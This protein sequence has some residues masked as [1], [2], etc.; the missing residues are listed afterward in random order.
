V[1]SVLADQIVPSLTTRV[2]RNS[3]DIVRT[4]SFDSSAK[5]ANPSLSY[6]VH[7]SGAT[8][9]RDIDANSYF[10]P[11]DRIARLYSS[12]AVGLT[13]KEAIKLGKNVHQTDKKSAPKIVGVNLSATAPDAFG[14]ANRINAIAQGKTVTR[15]KTQKH[16]WEAESAD[17]MREHHRMIRSKPGYEMKPVREAQVFEDF[18]EFGKDFG[19]WNP[20]SLNPVLHEDEEEATV[21]RSIARYEHIK[22]IKHIKPTSSMLKYLLNPLLLY[23]YLKYLLNPLYVTNLHLI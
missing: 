22:H 12:N 15:Q 20:E 3:T 21:E 2:S 9:Y 19:D 11:F 5:L 16:A 1:K 13:M 23:L 17:E 7:L 10:S 14:A 18:G 4:R 6:A 8:A